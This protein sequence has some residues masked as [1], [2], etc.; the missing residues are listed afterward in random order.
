MTKEKNKKPKDLRHRTVKESISIY[1]FELCKNAKNDLRLQQI[2][3]K[4]SQAH[5]IFYFF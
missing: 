5:S 1:S 4:A 2:L 3:T